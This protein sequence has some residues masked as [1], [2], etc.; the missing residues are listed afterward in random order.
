MKIEFSRKGIDFLSRFLDCGI[1]IKRL[2]YLFN[3]GLNVEC[4]I[5][6]ELAFVLNVNISILEIYFEIKL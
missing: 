3:F 2:R 5:D 4:Y 1:W 6:T